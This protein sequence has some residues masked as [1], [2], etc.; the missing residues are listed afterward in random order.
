MTNDA[1]TKKYA[2]LD[3]LQL[4]AL[5]GLMFIGTAFV[6]SATMANPIETEN[7]VVRRRSGSGR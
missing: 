4:A 2:E 7:T 1:S 3:R 5:A 6:F